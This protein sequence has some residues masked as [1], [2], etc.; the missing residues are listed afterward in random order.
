MRKNMIML[1]SA[2]SFAIVTINSASA[3]RHNIVLIE[4]FNN[5]GAFNVVC[6]QLIESIKEENHTTFPS[7][8]DIAVLPEGFAIEAELHASDSTSYKKEDF[9]A[10]E[11]SIRDFLE[12][13]FFSLGD[14]SIRKKGDALLNKLKITYNPPAPPKQKSPEE[15]EADEAKRLDAK[16]KQEEARIAKEERRKAKEAEAKKR[17]EEIKR[18]KEEKERIEAINAT[19]GS[20]VNTLIM[21][22]AIRGQANIVSTAAEKE[23]VKQ[24]LTNIAICKKEIAE[25]IYNKAN[26][27]RMKVNLANIE[28]KCSA[29]VLRLFLALAGGMELPFDPSFSFV[30]DIEH[31]YAVLFLAVILPPELNDIG[32]CYI[33]VSKTHTLAEL[34][35][36]HMIAEKDESLTIKKTEDGDRINFA[37]LRAPKI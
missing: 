23:T 8:A 26:D 29:K 13:H 24:M 31:H 36:H 3:V 18:K 2:L 35:Q 10:E 25:S 5:N 14:G 1:C 33:S 27:E 37:F 11:K 9:R 30:V 4:R 6:Q 17:E 7:Q 21:L 19:R 15:I 20:L 28:I 32:N 34:V 12:T 22:G 16:R